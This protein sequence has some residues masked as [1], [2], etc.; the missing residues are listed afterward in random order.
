MAESDAQSSSPEENNVVLQPQKIYLKD[1]SFET[2][3][4][5]EIFKLKWEPSLGVDIGQRVVELADD[6]YEVTLA[7]TATMKCG[8]STAY[9]AEA[10]QAG[11][12][13]IKGIGEEKLLHILNV[14]CPRMLYPYACSAVSEAVTRGGFP[15]LLLAPVSFE[16][17]YRQRQIEASGGD[18]KA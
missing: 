16:A 3:N 2:P 11:I 4:S 6:L 9:L 8:N 15:Q 7:L 17:I 18:K 13:L 10:H 12:F 5:P 14:Y 1:I